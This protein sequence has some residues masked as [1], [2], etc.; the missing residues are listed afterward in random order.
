MT[1]NGTKIPS[2][3]IYDSA[4]HLKLFWNKNYRSIHL[5]E[6]PYSQILFNMRVAVD[7]FHLKNHVH[8]ICKTI[9]NPDC[10]LN[11]NDEIYHGINTVIAEQLFRY[12]TEFKLSLRRL[13][14][15][16][17][18]IFS[19]LL[20]HLWNC[21]RTKISPDSFGLAMMYIPDKIKPLFQ[22]YSRLP[23]HPN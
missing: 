20:L 3:I 7:R 5:K 6:T 8:S 16:T 2:A 18:T 17:S 9:T 21:R 13:A 15:P 11:R 14:Y 10:A 12:L 1:K 22:T 4:C 19:I 23:D